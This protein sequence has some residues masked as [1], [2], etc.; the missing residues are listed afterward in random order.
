MRLASIIL[1][2][3]ALSSPLRADFSLPADSTQC[4]VGI[5]K[6]WDDSHITLHTYEKRDGN[7]LYVLLPEKSYRQHRAPWALP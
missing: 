3:L 6:G 4:V 1:S 2:L 7:P 5:A